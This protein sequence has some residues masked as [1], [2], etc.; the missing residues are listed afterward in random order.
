MSNWNYAQDT[1]TKKWRSAMTVPRKLSLHKVVDDYFLA[2]YPIDKISDLT[3]S[4]L[5]NEVEVAANT[6]DTLQ[7]EGLNQS[8][9]RLRTAAKILNYCLK[10]NWTRCLY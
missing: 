6:S 7:V 1:P 5:V 2:N 4:T 10:M 3:N 9:I 8:E